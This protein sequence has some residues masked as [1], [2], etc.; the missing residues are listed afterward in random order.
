MSENTGYRFINL[1][2]NKHEFIKAKSPKT[3]ILKVFGQIVVEDNKQYPTLVFRFE[4]FSG[5]EPY[6]SKITTDIS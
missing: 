1:K 3:L 4:H 6:Q 2:L 5:D